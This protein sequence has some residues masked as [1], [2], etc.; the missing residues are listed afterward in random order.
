MKNLVQVP[1]VAKAA[2]STLQPASVFWAEL[3]APK[4]DRFVGDCDAALSQQIFHFSKAHIESV[5]EPDRVADDFGRKSISV[6]A[7]GVAVH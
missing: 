2:L 7:R 3:E 5:V 1:R 4:P 6:V